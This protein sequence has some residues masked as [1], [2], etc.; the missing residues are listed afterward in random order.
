MENDTRTVQIAFIGLGQM[1]YHMAG[2]LATAG[3]PAYVYDLDTERLHRFK[4]EFNC[5]ICSSAHEAAEQ[6]D[7]VITMLP[8]S[9]DVFLTVLGGKSSPGISQFLKPGT[10]VIDMSSC[11]P[12]RTV[13]LSEILA[14]A[15]IVLVDAPVSGGVKKAREGTLTIMVGCSRQSFERCRQILKIMGSTIYHTGKTGT[16]HAMKALNNFVSATGLLATVEALRTGE[17]FGL[18]PHLMTQIL[19]ASTGKNYTTENKV[20][21]FM[22]SKSF[23]SGFSL[24]LMTKDIAIAMNLA[25]GLNTS[26]RLGQN[27][28]AIW[29][30]I[31]ADLDRIADHTEIYDLMVEE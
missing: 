9:D 26:T 12:L 16:G 14:E 17:K 28:L 3:Y 22:L 31:A 27:C 4:T 6:A 29:S 30:D 20:E 2:K 23:D 18:D 10:I 13:K 25:K 7:I 8:G 15:N 19:N 11:D 5:Q 21:Q 24:Q 1:G